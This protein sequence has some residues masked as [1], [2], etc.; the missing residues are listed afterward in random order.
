V[1]G[2]TFSSGVATALRDASS[3][4]GLLTDVSTPASFTVNSDGTVNGSFNPSA[5][6]QDV[7]VTN[8]NQLLEFTEAAGGAFRILEK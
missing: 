3:S 7:G 4:S 2:G 8:G 5:G 1:G 6:Q